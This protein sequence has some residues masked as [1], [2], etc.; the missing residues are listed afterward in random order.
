MSPTTREGGRRAPS[1][2]ARLFRSRTTQGFL[3]TAPLL[4]LFAAFVIYPM[5]F[6]VWYALDADSYRALFSDPTFRQTVV[7]TLWYVGFAVNVKLVLALLLSGILDFQFAWI[8][9][10][11][12]L[13]LIPWAVPALPGILSFRWMLNSQWGIFNH[14]LGKFGFA[15]VP[16]LAQHDTAL[17]AVIV[18]HIWKYLPFWTIIFLAGRRAIPIELYEATAIDGASALQNFRHVT[19]PLLRN[20]YLICTLLSMVFTLGD[21]TVP[22]LLTGGAPGD[23]THVLAT[24]AYRYTYTI[25]ADNPFVRYFWH[26]LGNSLVVALW[27]MALVAAVAALGSFAMARLHFRFRR[28]V[29]GLTLFTYVIPSSFLAIPFFKMMADYDLIDTKLSLIL[30]MVTFA[31]PYALWVLSDY[32]RSL[33]PEIEEA[34]AIDGAGTIATFL[35]LYLP[36]IRPPLI[37]IGT[38]AF[39]YAWNEYL[40]ALLLLTGEPRVT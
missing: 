39:L 9:V 7:N 34:G 2:V 30:A 16:W 20:L 24:L 22:W 36:L 10:L 29:S 25:G 18:F 40:Y 14:L 26:Q 13:F 37:A 33:P 19:F 17:G 28:F 11:A 38:Y 4:A 8:R 21:F 1:R 35:Y 3:F 27:A 6:G 31:A 5:A 12:A 32:A 15:S 23:S